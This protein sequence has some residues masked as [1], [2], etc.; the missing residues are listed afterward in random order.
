MKKVWPWK[1]VLETKVV[2]GKVRILREANIIPDT[3]D[4]QVALAVALCIAGFVAV[5]VMES[6]MMNKEEKAVSQA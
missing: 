1:E 3:F 4:G 6:A 2:R 5:L